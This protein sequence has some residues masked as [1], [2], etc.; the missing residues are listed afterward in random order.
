VP[1]RARLRLARG[2]CI[3][4]GGSAA[5][6]PWRRAHYPDRSIKC[7]DTPQAPESKANP[8]HAGPLTPP[9]NHIPA[10][11]R[12]PYSRGHLRHCTT[13]CGKASVNSVTL[14]RPLPYGR[15]AA[16]SKEDSGILEKGTDIYPVPT[17]DNALTSDQW[18]VSPPSPPALCGHPHHCATIPGIAAPSPALRKPGRTRHRHARCCAPYGLLSVSPSSQRTDGDQ[19]GSPHTATFEAATGRE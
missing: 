18:S 15:R 19:T 7:S 10:L 17:Q 3:P 1:P 4:S 6:G 5:T 12:Q 2:L 9:G 16:P 14:Y 13:L 11:F 8:R